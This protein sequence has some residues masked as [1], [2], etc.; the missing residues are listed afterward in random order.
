MPPTYTV[1]SN[2]YNTRGRRISSN[3]SEEKTIEDAT[4]RFLK[5]TLALDKFAGIKTVT[6]TIVRRDND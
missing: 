1:D 3:A 5:D 2:V 4:N 6:L